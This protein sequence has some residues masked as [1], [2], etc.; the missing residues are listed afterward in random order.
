MTILPYPKKISIKT[1]LP[2]KYVIWHGTFNRTKYTPYGTRAIK[3]TALLD[4]WELSK[5]K[6]GAPY[7][8]DRDGTIYKT[9]E[10]SDWSYH[11]NLPSTKGFFDKQSVPI[12]LANELHLLRENGQFFAFEYPH[13]TNTYLGPVV[14]ND[15][16]E[17]KYWA[18][19]DDAQVDAAL[20]LTLDICKR[21][22]IEPIFYVGKKSNSNLL[23]KATILTHS[24][25]N[26]SVTDFPPFD[27]YLIA[28]IKEKDIKIIN[29]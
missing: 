27:D 2:K 16:K 14:V 12:M 11:L 20:E 17:Y 4:Q 18:K 13:S 29:D 5:E 23:D 15:W 6:F 28:K 9:Y 19:L 26:P 10:D 24:A 1:T 8:I 3:P 21:H 25:V 22:N 7:L